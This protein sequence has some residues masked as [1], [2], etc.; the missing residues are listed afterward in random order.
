MNDEARALG[1]RALAAGMTLRDGILDGDADD[2]LGDAWRG[3]K[4]T[5]PDLRCPL[6]RGGLLADVR[7]RLGPYSFALRQKHGWSVWATNT[8]LPVLSKWL[9][10]T[11]C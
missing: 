5:W 9:K 1:L 6:T 10:S 8:A 4:D 2:R 7:E 11:T 3:T